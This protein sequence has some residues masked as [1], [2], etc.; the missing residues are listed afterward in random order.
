[1]PLSVMPRGSSIPSRLSSP[2]VAPCVHCSHH[3]TALCSAPGV[4]HLESHFHFSTAGSPHP[5]HRSC[6]PALR[7]LLLLLAVP[8]TPLQYIR[9]T[10]Q[11]TAQVGAWLPAPRTV[12]SAL[13]DSSTIDTP[14][15]WFFVAWTTRRRI[16]RGRSPARAQNAPGLGRQPRVYGR[17][18]ARVSAIAR[19]QGKLPSLWP[20]HVS[21]GHSGCKVRGLLQVLLVLL[22]QDTSR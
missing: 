5:Q 10:T 3:P 16:P 1:M 13:C 8:G 7:S 11:V 18:G 22:L 2:R 4:S 20:I 12:S 9:A 17:H 14:W 15:C 6:M 19:C 21:R